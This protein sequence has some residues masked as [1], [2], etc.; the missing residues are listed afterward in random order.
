MAGAREHVSRAEGSAAMTRLPSKVHILKIRQGT[1][2]RPEF[3]VI[4]QGPI[5]KSLPSPAFSVT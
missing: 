5:R 4:A 1:I 3:A 2:H